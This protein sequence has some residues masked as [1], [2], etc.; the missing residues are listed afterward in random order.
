MTDYFLCKKVIWNMVGATFLPGWLVYP[1]YDCGHLLLQARLWWQHVDSGWPVDICRVVPWGCRGQ[2][3]VTLSWWQQRPPSPAPHCHEAG[4]EAGTRHSALGTPQIDSSSPLV[5][6]A[7]GAPGLYSGDTYAYT[8]A[9]HRGTEA[10]V[11][12]SICSRYCRD[13]MWTL[14]KFAV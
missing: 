5:V 13:W 11:D 10:A 6:T 14:P 1:K 12:T 4:G 7:P 3:S 9:G 8:T 2:W